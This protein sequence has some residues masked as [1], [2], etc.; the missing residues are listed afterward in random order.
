MGRIS[1]AE[2]HGTEELFI[3]KNRWEIILNQ[4]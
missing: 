4:V 3:V 2:R 1:P